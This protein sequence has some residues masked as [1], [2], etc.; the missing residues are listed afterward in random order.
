MN[1]SPRALRLGMALVAAASLLLSTACS[2]QAEGSSSTGDVQV[3]WVP[4]L[5]WGAW[6]TTPPKVDGVKVELVPFKSSNEV[7]VALSSGS[8]Q[9]GALGFNNVAASLASSDFPAQFVA[10]AS[11]NSSIFLARKG[12]GIDG[13]GDLKGRKI[14]AV[15]GSSQ[16]VHLLTGMSQHGLDLNKDAEFV[17]LQTPTDLNLA[18]Q[19]GDIDALVTF[20]PNAVIAVMGGYG[21]PVPSIQDQLYDGSFAIS[22]GIAARRDFIQNRSQDVQKIVDA[23]YAECERYAKDKDAWAEEFVKFSPGDPKVIRKALDNIDP[24]FEMD[25]QQVRKVAGTLARLGEIPKDTTDA[26]VE[27]LNYDFI[28]KASGKTAQQLG[29]AE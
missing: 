25:E 13:W 29:K 17:S 8:I 14:G 28:A 6:A 26:L 27:R 4:A 10:G 12:S 16:Y 2:G 24:Y 22:S 9:M 7:L 11:T 3:G 1:R 21:V 15:R 23:Y 20:E 5:V 18:L 19:R